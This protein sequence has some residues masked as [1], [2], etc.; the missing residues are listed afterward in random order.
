ML[1]IIVGAE[2][3]YSAWPEGVHGDLVVAV[4]LAV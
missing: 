2:D 3:E 1:S 4:A